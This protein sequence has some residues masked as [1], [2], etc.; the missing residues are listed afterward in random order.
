[1]VILMM[2]IVPDAAVVVSKD[3]HQKQ[4]IHQYYLYN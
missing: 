2:M 3:R 1:M 4:I